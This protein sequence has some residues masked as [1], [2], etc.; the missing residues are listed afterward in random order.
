[1][2]QRADST[3]LAF[4]LSANLLWGTFPIY[5]QALEGAGALL[6]M[7]H[8]LLWALPFLMLVV[9]LTRQWGAASRGLRD[10]RELGLLAVSSAC[11][12]TSWWLYVWA[13]Q[14]ERIVEAS[15]GYYLTP[16][17]SLMVGLVMFRERLSRLRW[18]AVLLAAAG[19]LNLLAALGQ[20]PW[21]GVALGLLFGVYGGVRKLCR[22]EATPGLLIENLLLM[23]IA[24]GMFLSL[25]A[26]PAFD[27]QTRWLLIGSGT[28]SIVPIL[29]Y[30]AAVRRLPMATLGT[31]F[32]MAPTIGFLVGV[33]WFE[34]P[35]GTAHAATF[36]LIWSGLLLFALD[37]RTPKR[38]VYDAV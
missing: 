30:V 27:E 1:M 18:V 9:T 3:G 21:T 34:E 24:I 10:L 6:T 28:V 33:F 12:G 29:C 36:A 31:L 22:T 23:P 13:A 8:R 20:V 14:N 25:D 19:V 15:M 7:A 16:I 17:I 26:S 2:L 37:G 4:A 35:F 32:Y 38:L 5:F 11:M